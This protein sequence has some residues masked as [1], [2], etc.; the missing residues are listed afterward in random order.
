M[1]QQQGR[2]L[3]WG[4]VL[5]CT[6]SP[7]AVA[8]RAA[9]LHRASLCGRFMLPVLLVLAMPA[10][11]DS[12]RCG[13]QLIHTGDSEAQVLKVCG[14]PLE[15]DSVKRDFWV[16]GLLRNVR[17]QRWHYR[18]PG[19]KLP[20]EVLIYKGEVVGISLGERRQAAGQKPR[21]F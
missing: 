7:P 11:A 9:T 14:E 10:Q 4:M 6:N 8:R 5:T 19:G 15:R 17:L 13:K 20:R 3:V 12:F 1:V 16:N 2:G 21:G 18:P